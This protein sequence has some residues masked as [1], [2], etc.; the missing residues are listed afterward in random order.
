MFEIVVGRVIEEF[1]FSKVENTFQLDRARKK[2]TSALGTG[3]LF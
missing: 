2:E 3:S 1:I